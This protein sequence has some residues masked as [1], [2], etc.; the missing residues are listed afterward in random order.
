[1]RS[2]EEE[3]MLLDGGIAETTNSVK[4]T[5][6]GTI[7]DPWQQNDPNLPKLTSEERKEA[8][9]QAMENVRNQEP[10]NRVYETSDFAQGLTQGRLLERMAI[11]LAVQN[12]IAR[13]KEA[14]PENVEFIQGAYAALKI[15]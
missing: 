15:V 6:I 11:K 5:P 4:S 2:F 3:Q 1:M 10:L 8:W 9:N 12:E 7:G 14:D 13:L